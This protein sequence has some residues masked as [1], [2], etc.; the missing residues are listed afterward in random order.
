MVNANCKRETNTASST[1]P[2]VHLTGRSLPESLCTK[3][4]R[5]ATPPA[6]V[7]TP[8]RVNGA[9][10]GSRSRRPFRGLEA[11]VRAA[12]A[13]S[14]AGLREQRVLHVEQAAVEAARPREFLVGATLD[15]APG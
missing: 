5:F 11:Y 3:R 8:S 12:P 1:P 15:D 10:L 6:D 2:P 7:P 9:V 13:R 4:V 14:G